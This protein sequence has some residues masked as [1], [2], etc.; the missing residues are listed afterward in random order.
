MAAVDAWAS[1][2]TVIPGLKGEVHR[3]YQP[4]RLGPS[5]GVQPASKRAQAS[6][7]LKVTR[8]AWVIEVGYGVVSVSVHEQQKRRWRVCEARLSE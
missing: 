7:G 1:I 4:C 3:V 2:D 5:A 8:F 6:T